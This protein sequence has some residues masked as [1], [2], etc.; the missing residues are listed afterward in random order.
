MREIHC[1]PFQC[2][3]T[4]AGLK[5]VMN[6]YCSVNGEPVVGSKKMLTDILRGEMGFQGFVVSDYF[7]T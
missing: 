6:S 7:V 4:E 3:I 5:S 1:K 2:A